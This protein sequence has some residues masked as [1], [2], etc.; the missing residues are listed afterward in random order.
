MTK[1]SRTDNELSTTLEPLSKRQKLTSDEKD[2]ECNDREYRT[3]TINGESDCFL[4]SDLLQIPF[5][6]SRYSSHWQ[7]SNNTATNGNDCIIQSDAIEFGMNELKMVITYV[8]NQH[9][10]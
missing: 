4:S 6:N 2:S 1:R 5:F 3:V 7:Q 8:T 9:N 10:L